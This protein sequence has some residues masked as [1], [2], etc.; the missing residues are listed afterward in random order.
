MQESLKAQGKNLSTQVEEEGSKLQND[1]QVT[2]D[3]VADRGKALMGDAKVKATE[4]KDKIVRWCSI[5]VNGWVAKGI[6]SDEE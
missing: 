3:Q 6:G 4:I 2:A 1:A 5:V